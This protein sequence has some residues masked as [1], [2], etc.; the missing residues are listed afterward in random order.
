MKILT[1]LFIITHAITFFPTQALSAEKIESPNLINNHYLCW[2][3][4]RPKEN[5]KDPENQKYVFVADQWNK[6]SVKTEGFDFFC[7][8]LLRKGDEEF[9]SSPVHLTCYFI[10]SVSVSEKTAIIRNQFTSENGAAIRTRFLQ[11]ICFPTVKIASG[12]SLQPPEKG[13]NPTPPPHSIT[14]EQLRLIMRGPHYLC[15]AANADHL[16]RSPLNLGDQWIAN[17]RGRI[18]KLVKFCNPVNMKQVK[19]K[20]AEEFPAYEH[21]ACYRVVLEYETNALIEN[22]I[23]HPEAKFIGVRDTVHVCLPTEKSASKDK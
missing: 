22:Q 5:W 23:T 19:G 1:P 21:L 7:N 12:H 6:L 13:E 11:N 18:G 3:V 4:I 2:D 17:R 8:P 9:P 10:E 14:E 16:G 20:K 15:Y